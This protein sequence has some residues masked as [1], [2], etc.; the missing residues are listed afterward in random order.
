MPA[1]I[2]WVNQPP[3]HELIEHAPFG[4]L[5]LC[6]TTARYEQANAYSRHLFGLHESAGSLPDAVWATLL[7]EDCQT[8]QSSPQASGQYRHLVLPSEQMIQWSVFKL[9]PFSVVFVFDV[10]APYQARQFSRNLLSSLSHEL[11]TPLAT[12]LT[13]LEILS[14]PTLPA[15][16]MAQSLDLLKQEGE[17]LS[18]LVNQLLQLSQLETEAPAEQHYLDLLPLAE[19]VVAQLSPLAQASGMTLMLQADAP[20]PPIVGDGN[21]LKQVW[22]NLVENAI[23]HTP[24]GTEIRVALQQTPRGIRCLVVDNGPG[25]PAEQLPYLT[26]Y[27]YRAAPQKSAGSGLGLALVAEILRGHRSQLILDSHTEGEGRGL[28]AHFTLPL[29]PKQE[30]RP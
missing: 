12:M 2:A 5:L 10:T 16:T 4:W 29:A 7:Q 25:V 23:K 18:L 8:S 14:M 22:L 3:F 13:H 19:A 26:H 30:N 27:F 17:R 21:R 1:P 15:E 11:R 20:L 28:Q 24:H 9:E 6:S